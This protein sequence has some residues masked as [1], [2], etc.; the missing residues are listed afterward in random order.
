MTSCFF[1][2]GCQYSS[3]VIGAAALCPASSMAVEAS[4]PGESGAVAVRG[5]LLEAYR[6]A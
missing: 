2:S 4:A 1:A 3:I 6:P 5:A